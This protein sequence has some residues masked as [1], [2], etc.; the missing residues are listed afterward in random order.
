MAKLSG[1]E[2]ERVKKQRVQQENGEERVEGE[3]RE[4]MQKNI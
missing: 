1:V 4:E 3:S 2:E